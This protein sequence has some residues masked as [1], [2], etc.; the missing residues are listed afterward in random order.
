LIYSMGPEKSFVL[1]DDEEED[2][3]HQILHELA[4]HCDF[5]EKEEV[6]YGLV[7]GI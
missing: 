1:E 6:R 2:L 7:I 3:D 5:H 4:A